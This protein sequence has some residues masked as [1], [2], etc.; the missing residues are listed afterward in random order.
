MANN[1]KGGRHSKKVAE[2]PLKEKR[3]AKKAKKSQNSHQPL[4]KT[5]GH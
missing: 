2:K 5:F 1:D 3:P 4:D